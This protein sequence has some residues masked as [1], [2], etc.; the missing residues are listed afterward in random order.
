M[1]HAATL[2]VSRLVWKRK[3]LSRGLL[4]PY[5]LK[6]FYIPNGPIHLCYPLKAVSDEM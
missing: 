6:F 1:F 2:P 5:W 4:R 3:N